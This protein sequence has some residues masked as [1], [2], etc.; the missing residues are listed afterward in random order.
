[1]W[2]SAAAFN[3]DFVRT[4]T[5]RGGTN[6]NVQVNMPA[7]LSLSDILAKQ[8]TSFIPPGCRRSRS[9]STAC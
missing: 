8:R 3:F 2:S 9:G 1:M 5:L 7:N 4:G 6:M